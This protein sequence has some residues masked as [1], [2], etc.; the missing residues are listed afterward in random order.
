MS[1]GQEGGDMTRE[2]LLKFKK[3]DSL[4]TVWINPVLVLRIFEII[5]QK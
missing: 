2:F 5:I 3:S 1:N 4:F